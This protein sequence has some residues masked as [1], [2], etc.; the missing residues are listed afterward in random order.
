M[1]DS[2]G[3]GKP[4]KAARPRSWRSPAR[5]RRRA[6]AH[7]L[8]KRANRG[9]GERLRRAGGAVV[10]EHLQQHGCLLPSGPEQRHEAEGPGIGRLRRP[11]RGG[12]G[13][14]GAPARAPGPRR[15]RQGSGRRAR[16]WS[17]RSGRPGPGGSRPRGWRAARRRGRR[18]PP[19]PGRRAGRGP[20]QVAVGPP[21]SRGG[22]QLT[23]DAPPGR[24][25]HRRRER[26][27]DCCGERPAG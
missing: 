19:G 8:N 12:A 3:P 23:R 13:R 2:G 18:P 4:L 26:R 5:Q 24:G 22:H 7:I 17:A 10:R 21:G 6:F 11:G 27:T 15:A 14:T 16:R 25:Q 20:P 1:S 9:D